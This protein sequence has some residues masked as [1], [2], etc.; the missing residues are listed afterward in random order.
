AA[1]RQAVYRRSLPLA[2]RDLRIARS[3][4]SDRAGVMG[5][6]FMVIDELFSRERL[7]SWIDNGTPIGR[8]E[9]IHPTATRANA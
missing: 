6:A 2:T 8:S 5:A 7:G 9:V 3:P 4:L 1:I